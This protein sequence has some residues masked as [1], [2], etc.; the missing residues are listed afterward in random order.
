MLKDPI[1]LD[2]RGNQPDYSLNFVS[3]SVRLPFIRRTTEAVEVFVFLEQGFLGNR[4]MNPRLIDPRYLPDGAGELPLERPLVIELLDEFGGSEILA[5]ED[6]ESDASPWGRPSEARESR[7]SYT[8]SEGTS[9]AF[10]SEDI[11]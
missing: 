11:W 7:R 9:I 3:D 1:P 5:V 6:L 8:L 2:G 10:P 4:D